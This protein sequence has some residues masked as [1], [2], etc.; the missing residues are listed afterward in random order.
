MTGFSCTAHPTSDLLRTA[1]S[2]NSSARSITAHVR[3]QCRSVGLRCPSRCRRQD[4][5]EET[6]VGEYLASWQWQPL[7]SIG[8]I[9]RDLRV[10]LFDLL[11]IFR[12]CQGR[13][14]E[15]ESRFPL[16][17]FLRPCSVLPALKAAEFG[18][19]LQVCQTVY[20]CRNHQ[21]TR[22]T[23][24]PSRCPAARRLCAS[25][26]S[27]SGYSAAIGTC[28]FTAST[29]LFRRSNSPLPETKL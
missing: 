13:G 8:T 24:F 4:P 12:S 26:A 18:R 21:C 5:K 27:A 15:F 25:A 22:N 6:Y 9:W 2:I 14:R 11:R 16:H 10:Y 17:P 20:A 19:R 29:A 23:I 7:D 1:I 28:S 3:Q